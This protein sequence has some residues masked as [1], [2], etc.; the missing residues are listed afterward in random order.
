MVVCGIS[1][2]FHSAAERLLISILVKIN[3]FVLQRIEI[4]LQWRFVQ[5]KSCR[6]RFNVWQPFLAF[7]ACEV[8]CA[9]QDHAILEARVA[10][11]ADA[12]HG[13]LFLPLGKARLVPVEQAAKL[14]HALLEGFF[15]FTQMFF[16]PLAEGGEA[17]FACALFE[18]FAPRAVREESRELLFGIFE[19]E[20]RLEAHRAEAEG[21]S[22]PD[23]EAYILARLAEGEDFEQSAEFFGVQVLE[24]DRAGKMC[25]GGDGA[26]FLRALDD[27]V[28]LGVETPRVGARLLMP[29]ELVAADRRRAVPVL[30]LFSRLLQVE[31]EGGGIRRHQRM[32]TRR[33]EL[34]GRALEHGVFE[35]DAPRP[36][37]LAAEDGVGE[38][39]RILLKRRRHMVGD[40]FLVG[41]AVVAPVTEVLHDAVFRHVEARGAE[42]DFGIVREACRFPAL[43]SLG[44]EVEASAAL[45]LAVA[46]E[47][48][49]G[50]G[51][52][53]L[54][55]PIRLAY[56]EVD[57]LLLRRA[58]RDDVGALLLV[59]PANLGAVLLFAARNLQAFLVGGAHVVFAAHSDKEARIRLG[60]GTGDFLFAAV[61]GLLL[62]GDIFH[63][64]LLV[65]VGKVAA[66][67]DKGTEV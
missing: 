66:L 42:A 33:R 15:P 31:L 7:S 57:V 27:L 32:G 26:D 23:L 50:H 9:L 47:D 19:Q 60:D 13:G 45:V 58:S 65:V 51:Q 30:R 17:F 5:E 56:A 20:T 3:F 54:L 21:F 46:F 8:E 11:V 35:D 28:T 55:A 39:D 53:A 2:M 61:S 12:H 67:L 14:L 6:T 59:M 64:A 16:A 43:E 4:A 63:H 62:D 29:V 37:R 49:F 1:K 44:E 36:K 52:A 48:A 34:L 25:A 40:G 18:A 38:V 41:D 10:F 24:A 22:L